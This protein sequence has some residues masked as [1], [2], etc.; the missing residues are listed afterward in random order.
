MKATALVALLGTIIMATLIAAPR[1]QQKS[2]STLFR[3]AVGRLEVGNGAWQFGQWEK[4]RENAE[5]RLIRS[6]GITQV[7]RAESPDGTDWVV[8]EFAVPQDIQ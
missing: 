2:K 5:W 4:F 7:W 3:E 8:W 6:D 1:Q